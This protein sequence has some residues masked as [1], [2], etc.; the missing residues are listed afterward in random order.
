MDEYALGNLYNQ[1][2]YLE[3]IC[4]GRVERLLL[5]LTKRNFTALSFQNLFSQTSQ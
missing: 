3:Y 4:V 2:Q 1:V 5:S